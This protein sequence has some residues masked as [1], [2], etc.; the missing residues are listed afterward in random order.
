[1]SKKKSNTT[2]PNEGVIFN[3]DGSVDIPGTILALSSVSPSTLNNPYQINSSY[4]PNSTLSTS[5]NLSATTYDPIKRIEEIM[6][7]IELLNK[8][9]N[10][11]M[12]LI[13]EERGVEQQKH[14]KR[15]FK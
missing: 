12:K 4:T 8:E 5:M 2:S 6:S 13:I 7:N 15:K 11:L 3:I 14:P 1:M 10:I 9:A